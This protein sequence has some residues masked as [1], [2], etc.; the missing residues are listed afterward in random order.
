VSREL[1]R[2]PTPEPVETEA[3]RVE[4]ELSGCEGEVRRLQAA[5]RGVVGRRRVGRLRGRLRR[6]ERGVVGLQS[7]IRGVSVREMFAGHLQS[8]RRSV[9][10]STMVH[11]PNHPPTPLKHSIALRFAKTL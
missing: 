10:W 7:L 11:L 1:A 2:E 6:A 5:A 3:E 4:R 9:E 8:Y